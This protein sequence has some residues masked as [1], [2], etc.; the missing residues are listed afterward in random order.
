MKK[1]L[2]GILLLFVV[3][4]SIPLVKVVKR[5]INEYSLYIVG[6]DLAGISYETPVVANG[7]QIGYV[8]KT[9]LVGSQGVA[10]LCIEKK[11]KIPRSSEVSIISQNIFN[12]KAVQFTLKQ[13]IQNYSAGDTI[14]LGADSSFH[15]E[16][17][18][19]SDVIVGIS[20]AISLAESQHEIDSLRAE[21]NSRMTEQAK[22]KQ[23]Q[24]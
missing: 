15:G 11:F 9:N 12:Q 21:L 4:G 5:W 2:F 17:V 22:I 16:R 20:T 3:L 13:S 19:L 8:F 10:Q 24:K 14:S 18:S 1:V 6:N 7:V 23:A